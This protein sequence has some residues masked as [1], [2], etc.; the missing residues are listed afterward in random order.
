M[1]TKS[2]AVGASHVW[3]ER[4]GERLWNLQERTLELLL[5]RNAAA[6]VGVV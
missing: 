6:Q 4:V 5:L 1:L 3:W 2:M